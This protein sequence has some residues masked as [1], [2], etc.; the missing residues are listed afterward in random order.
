MSR[1]LGISDLIRSLHTVTESLEHEHC[2][3]SEIQRVVAS[4]FVRFNFD[5]E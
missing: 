4:E 5:F 1:R 3:L 2:N